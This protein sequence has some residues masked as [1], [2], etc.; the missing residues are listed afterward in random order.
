MIMMW[1]EVIH[2]FLYMHCPTTI[3]NNDVAPNFLEYSNEIL[4]EKFSESPQSS[5]SNYESGKQISLS[6]VF[7]EIFMFY[8]KSPQRRTDRSCD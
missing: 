6:S 3:M 7:T 5:N 2:Y 1:V 4:T 8:S